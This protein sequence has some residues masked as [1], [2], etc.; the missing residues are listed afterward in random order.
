MKTA[1]AKKMGHPVPFPEELPYR[2]IQLYSYEKD[3]VLDP[4]IGSGTTAVACLKN[5]RK[6]IGYEINKDYIKLA[7]ER[8]L[9]LQPS[10]FQN[11]ESLNL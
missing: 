4:F 6:F 5:E 2:L 9:S 7:N 10:L 11:K 8:L 3:I 1:S